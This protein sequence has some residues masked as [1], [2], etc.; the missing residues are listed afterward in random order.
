MNWDDRMRRNNT[1]PGPFDG[2]PVLD[3]GSFCPVADLPGGTAGFGRVDGRTVYI[4]EFPETLDTAAIRAICRCMRQ[5]GQNGAPFVSIVNCAG[6]KI[7]EGAAVVD[8]AAGLLWERARLSGVAPQITVVSGAC[9]GL[10]GVFAAMGDAVV[11]T[12]NARLASAGAGV[13]AAA[14]AD[15]PGAPSAHNATGL[16]AFTVDSMEAAHA[17]TRELLSFLPDNN[18]CDPPVFSND[19]AN[20]LVP[21]LDAL[22][23]GYG[24]VREII[25]TLVDGRDFCEASSGFGPGAATLFA[26]FC[27][28]AVGVAGINPGARL[29]ADSLIKITRF[30]RLCDSF[31]LPLVVFADCEGLA[32]DA[33]NEGVVLIQAAGL[34]DTLAGFSAPRITVVTGRFLGAACALFGRGLG[35]DAVLA[36]P[37]AEIAPMSAEGMTSVLAQSFDTADPV[38]ARAKAADDYRENMADPWSALKAGLVDEVIAPSATRAAI[39]ARLGPLADKRVAKPPRKHGCGLGG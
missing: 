4:A 34:A 27:G 25:A 7:T 16:V 35:T 5:A 38:A 2:S 8:G 13:L 18:L 26:R 19:S 21:E 36:W 37:C 6:L 9:E 15:K 10:C 11:M 31:H 30:A 39:C 23:E 3:S 1:G 22:G 29:C 24:D 20:R 32:V 33:V 17:K 14:G 12:Q 28:Q